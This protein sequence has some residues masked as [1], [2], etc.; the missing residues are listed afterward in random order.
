MKPVSPIKGILFDKDGTLFDFQATWGV[1]AQ[2]FFL[3]LAQG[4]VQLAAEMGAKLGYDY[5]AGKFLKGSIVIA[6]TAE[7][8]AKEIALIVPDWE[9]KALFDHLNAT[10]A[11][12][13]QLEA[14]PLIPL[15]SGFRANG[16]KL[17]VATNDA[18]APAR[19]HLD[20]AG[21]TDLFD[22]VAG[23][24][25]GF[26]GKPEIGMMTGFCTNVGLQA[27]EVLMVGDSLHDLIAGRRAGMV[28]AGVLTGLLSA[29]E[30]A[31]HAD[32]VLADIGGLPDFLRRFRT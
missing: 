2:G 32:V 1:W 27:H 13:P 31:P 19:A 25:S 24:D 22:F 10:V 8:V 29:D 26:G 18:E 6:H 5:A 16:L 11:L 15:L 3:D 21:V 17:G 7:E 4:D 28:T 30:L 9:E 12:A 20:H 14:V 23:S